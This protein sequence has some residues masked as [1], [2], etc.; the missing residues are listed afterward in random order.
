MHP[1]LEGRRR[2]V[3]KK[4][5]PRNHLW[6]IDA[7]ESQKG[8]YS[9]TIATD[10]IRVPSLLEKLINRCFFNGSPG[11]KT[12]L[13]AY[14]ASRFADLIYSVCGPLA[15]ARFFRSTL[16]VSWVFREPPSMT[17]TNGFTYSAY[18]I[19]NLKAHA[20]FLTLTPNAENKFAHYAPAR[21]LPWCVDLDIFD[22]KPSTQKPTR[23]FFLA[24]G[25]TERDY[26]TLAKAALQ[27]KADIRIIG[28]ASARPSNSP[29]NLFW[30]NTSQEPTDQAIN[31]NTLRDW[32]AQATAICIPLNG[33]A[34]DTCG[35]TNLLE[36]MA[37]AKPVL[38]TRS[39]CLH[40]DPETHRCGYLID[41]ASPNHWSSSMNEILQK[42]NLAASL[43]AVGRNIAKKEFSTE[44]FNQNIL[45]FLSE[46]L[47]N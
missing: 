7:I 14:R 23:P 1:Y 10:N 16:L 25:K 37:M 21:F 27:V 36:G 38:M 9:Q 44:R 20:G 19:Q 17:N 42:P 31:Y 34:N 32:Y 47:S 35:Y 39:G 28:P 6:G 11:V 26:E 40:F 45:N 15:L 8:W 24:T 43:G 4:L 33:D 29:P 5:Y 18:S 46:R 22:G 12:E 2:D 13:A 41:P 3:E 30:T